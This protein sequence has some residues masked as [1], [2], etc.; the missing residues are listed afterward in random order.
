MTQ[1]TM[2]AALILIFSLSLS[3]V[4]I[5]CLQYQMHRSYGVFLFLFYIAFLVVAILA[6]LKVFQINIDGVLSVI[7]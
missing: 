4:I 3:L 6:E 1:V 2:L 5:S 7:D